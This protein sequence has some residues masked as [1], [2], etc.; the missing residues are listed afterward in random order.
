MK[1]MSARDAFAGIPGI[2]VKSSS[3]GW[4]SLCVPPELE[5]KKPVVDFFRELMK[6]ELSEEL[7][8]Q[9]GMA[10]DELLSNAIEHGCK[11]RPRSAVGLSFI[12]TARSVVLQLRDAGTGFSLQNL[13]HAAVNNP[14]EDPLRHAKFRSRMGLRPGGFGI[15]LVRQIADELIYNEHG[16]EV[17]LIKYL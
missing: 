17:M 15:M 3:P 12:R 7:A 16:N 5:L 9:L 11:V 4:I 2:E 13:K 14:P 8:E 1:V 6:R 10:I